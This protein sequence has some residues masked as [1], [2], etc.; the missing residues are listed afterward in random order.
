MARRSEW[1][2]PMGDDAMGSNAC[3]RE[4]SLAAF[5]ELRRAFEGAAEE[6]GLDGDEDVMSVIWFNFQPLT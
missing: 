1:E 5:D 6:A 2:G 4:D 3:D